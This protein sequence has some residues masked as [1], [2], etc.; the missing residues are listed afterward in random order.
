MPKDFDEALEPLLAKDSRYPREAYHFVREALDF[1]QQA[2]EKANHGK[3]RHI[4][5]QEL[6][7][8]IRDFALCQFG[9]MSC[10]VLEDWGIKSCED[11]GEIVFNLVE[12]HILSKTEEDS[13]N[14]FKG[15]YD[16]EEA[17]RRPFEPALKGN[18]DCHK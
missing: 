8:G 4:S 18:R 11:F 15:G 12:Q 5:G 9:P 10:C 7:V 16:F 6:L 17:F 1:T 13:R 2:V 14:D 3:P